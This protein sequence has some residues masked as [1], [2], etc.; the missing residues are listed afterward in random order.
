ME[1]CIAL[2]SSIEVYDDAE[3]RQNRESAVIHIEERAGDCAASPSKYEC[4]G[5]TLRQ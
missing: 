5:R 2:F 4:L 3:F 1:T